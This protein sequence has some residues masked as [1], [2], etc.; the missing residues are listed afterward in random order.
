MDTVK[1]KKRLPKWLYKI[2]TGILMVLVFSLWAVI[3]LLAF[4]CIILYVVIAGGWAMI[5]A[6]NIGLAGTLEIIALQLRKNPQ[7]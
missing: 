2:G 7:I 3:R 4:V 6:G 1:P 5:C